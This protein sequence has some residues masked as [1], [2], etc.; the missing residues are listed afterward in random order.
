MMSGTVV[1]WSA[2]LPVVALGNVV[3]WTMVAVTL[4]RSAERLEARARQFRWLQLLL[5]AGYVFGCAYRSALPVFDVPR[6]ALV[7]SVLSTALVGRSVATLAELCFVAQ[8]ALLLRETSRAT[9]S[10]F[11]HFAS[12]VVVPLIVVAEVCSWYSVL[13]T[14]NLG[15]V[16]E[17]SLWSVATSLIIAGLLATRQRSGHHWRVASV[18]IAVAGMGYLLYLWLVDIPMYWAR[19]SAAESAGKVYLSLREGWLSASGPHVVSY[20]WNLWRSEMAWM[21]IYFSVA[22]WTSIWLVRVPVPVPVPRAGVAIRQ[23]R[24]AA[25]PDLVGFGARLLRRARP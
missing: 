18:W 16:Y 23:S 10:A 20:S 21:G 19:W 3:A 15:H 24:R 14:S 7:H 4:H 9:G 13:T 8:W 12:R 1:I 17:E 22:V 6:V 25:P 2:V 11:G 5:S